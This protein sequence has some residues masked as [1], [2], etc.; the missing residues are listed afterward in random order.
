MTNHFR[1]EAEVPRMFQTGSPPAVQDVTSLLL[2]RS[3]VHLH[4]CSVH[5]RLGWARNESSFLV[6]PVK[7]ETREDVMTRKKVKVPKKGSIWHFQNFQVESCKIGFHKHFQKLQ[8]NV[9]RLFPK[10]AKKKGSI[11]TTAATL[12]PAARWPRPS[13][14]ACRASSDYSSPNQSAEPQ[15]F[16]EQ[17]RSS[18]RTS[19]SAEGSLI[20][21]LNW[22]YT[23]LV[24]NIEH[25]NMHNKFNLT[26]KDFL[27]WPL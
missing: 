12:P 11:S 24:I 14:W 16:R 18:R 8:K 9:P 1:A 15:P 7:L 2:R 26:L 19:E 20:C 27:F 17:C 22:T 5:G 6:L 21:L 10:V 23:I 25:L 3:L 13:C 4:L